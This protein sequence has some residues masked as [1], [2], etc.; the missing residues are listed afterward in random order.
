MRTICLATIVAS[1]VLVAVASAQ[2]YSIR[3][4]RGLNLRA[5]PSLYAEIAG[6]VRTGAI[7]L[8]IG[9][10]GDW[11]KINRAGNA[12][13]LADWV[14][15][16][17]LDTSGESSRSSTT[18]QI[19]NCCFVDR[20]CHSDS[21]WIDGYWAYQNNQCPTSA[22]SQTQTASQ[23]PNSASTQVDNCCYVDRLCQTDRQWLDGFWAY[24]NSQCGPSASAPSAGISI[25]GSATFVARINAALDLLKTRA[26]QWHAYVTKGPLRIAEDPSSAWDGYASEGSIYISPSAAAK[27]SRIL[28]ELLVHEATH[29]HRQ[30]A[31]L[32]RYESQLDRDFEEAL[33]EYTSAAAGQQ[34]NY[35]R[36]I[37]TYTPAQ[38]AH[39]IRY[40]KIEQRIGAG[41]TSVTYLPSDVR[42][43]LRAGYD[44]FGALRAE[45][46]R[47]ARLLG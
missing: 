41:R 20:Q 45:I 40:G 19:D 28:A 3:A 16:S 12:V 43:L 26:P 42:L 6:T 34:I 22:G 44:V 47:A 35:G 33:A 21:Q 32:M 25:E 4:N 46:A 24:Q 39:L 5:A 27:L 15:Y 37:V 30:L 38:V 8:V 14:N 9:E 17:R 23:S 10:S 18:A 29:A 31:G 13:W 2:G 36:M 7:L 11:L 1:F